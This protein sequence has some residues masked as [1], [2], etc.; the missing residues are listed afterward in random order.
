MKFRLGSETSP[1]TS[2]GNQQEHAEREARE[3]D[4]WI[5]NARGLHT[6]RAGSIPYE[7]ITYVVRNSAFDRQ[8]VDAV[9]VRELALAHRVF[10]LH[11]E[12][13]RRADAALGGERA[14]KH[15]PVG[16]QRITIEQI[17]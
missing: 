8:H 10:E 11:A 4:H 16:L 9:F 15:G 12:D 1:G 5:E 14:A 6:M 7:L 2:E 3:R 13:L 17:F